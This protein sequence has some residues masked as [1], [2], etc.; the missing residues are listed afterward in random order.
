MNPC[1]DLARDAVLKRAFAASGLVITM[2]AGWLNRHQQQVIH[3]W[4]TKF[5]ETFDQYREAA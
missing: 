5:T 1:R 2:I 3:D 4:D